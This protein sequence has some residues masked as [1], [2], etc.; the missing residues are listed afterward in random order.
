MTRALEGFEEIP[1]A[2][3]LIDL[4]KTTIRKYQ[5]GKRQAIMKYIVSC[6]RNSF[7]FTTD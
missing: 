5:T 1:K 6:S 7:Q 2:E 3:I 4:L